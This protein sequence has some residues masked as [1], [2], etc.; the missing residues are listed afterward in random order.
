MSQSIPISQL[1]ASPAASFNSYGDK[2]SGRITA[3]KEQQ[4]TDPVTGKVKQFPSGD[5]MTLWIITIQPDTGEAISLWAKAGRY[6]AAKGSGKSMLAAIVDAVKASGATALDVG[7]MLAVAY[8]GETEAKPGLNPAK[9]FTAQYQPPAPQAAS[10]P[11][12]L[13]S[14]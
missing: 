8:T 9:L 10:L 1:E 11:V 3:M 14:T 7:G 6:V 4:Q 2:Y 12:D 13:F 5:P